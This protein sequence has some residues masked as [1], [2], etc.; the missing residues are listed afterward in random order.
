[1][2]SVTTD[3]EQLT[4]FMMKN[5]EGNYQLDLINENPDKHPNYFMSLKRKE[6]NL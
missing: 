4:N 6:F 3:I 2:R 1:V 5:D